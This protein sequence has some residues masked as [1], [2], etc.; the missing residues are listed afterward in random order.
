MPDDN[1][2]SAW[3]AAAAAE[4]APRCPTC[5]TYDEVEL[6]TVGTDQNRMRY[7]YC[8]APFC[9]TAFRVGDL[10]EPKNRELHRRYFRMLRNYLTARPERRQPHTDDVLARTPRASEAAA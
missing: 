4:A 7:W 1:P 10:T 5:D 6:V 8:G 3:S 2:P 9:H